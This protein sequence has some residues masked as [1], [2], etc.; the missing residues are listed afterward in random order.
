MTQK[1]LMQ[2]VLLAS[3][4]LTTACIRTQK[5]QAKTKVGSETFTETFFSGKMQVSMPTRKNN[6][7]GFGNPEIYKTEF[8]GIKFVAIKKNLNQGVFTFNSGGNNAA[9]AAIRLPV[10]MATIRDAIKQSVI[11]ETQKEEMTGD[12]FCM[13]M[14]FKN[15]AGSS[16]ICLVENFA[17]GFIADGP[18]QESYVNSL[19]ML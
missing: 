17:Y 2:A 7:G 18:H 14:T 4:A 16:K 11:I 5:F 1:Y 13:R 3:V 6:I 12:Y 15:K 19:K 8:N 10:Y 9:N